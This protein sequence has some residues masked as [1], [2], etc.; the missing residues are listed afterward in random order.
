MGQPFFVLSSPPQVVVHAPLALTHTL[1]AVVHAPS[2]RLCSPTLIRVPNP[3][4]VACP[5]S[6]ACMHATTLA[7]DASAAAGSTLHSP[8]HNHGVHEYS[9]STP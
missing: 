9:M 3:S 4:F 8:T 6:H 2:S 7:A 1:P 5:Q